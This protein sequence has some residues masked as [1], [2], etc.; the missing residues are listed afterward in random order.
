MA[1]LKDKIK[2]YCQL[3]DEKDHIEEQLNSLKT[4]IEFAMT[5]AN[6][7]EFKDPM[8]GEA[9]FIKGSTQERVDST[10]VKAYC[11]SNQLNYSM[12][13]K[14]INVKDHIVIMS[15]ESAKARKQFIETKK[16]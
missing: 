6:L 2:L 16:N 4:E 7:T 12:F 5:Q 1:E 14:V 3:K 10:A 11:L 8:I 13:V 9:K 15:P